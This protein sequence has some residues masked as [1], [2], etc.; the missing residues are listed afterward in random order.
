M[1]TGFNKCP[2][3]ILVIKCSLT[4]FICRS[5]AQAKIGNYVKVYRLE[6]RIK[7]IGIFSEL[8]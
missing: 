6:M 7:L 8:Y 3:K 1:F 4:N 5:Y 2:H